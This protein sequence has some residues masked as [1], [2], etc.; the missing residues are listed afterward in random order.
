MWQE[1]HTFS[2]G[3]VVPELY[4]FDGIQLNSAVLVT[5][6]KQQKKKIGKP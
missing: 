5:G 4:F 3:I 2:T 6:Q 1:H